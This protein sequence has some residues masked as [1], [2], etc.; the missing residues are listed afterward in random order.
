MVERMLHNLLA[1][2]ARHTPEDATIWVTCRTGAADATIE[3]ADDGPGIAPEDRERVFEPF[4]Q[5]P[6]SRTAPSP[7]TGIGLALVRQFAVLHGGRVAVGARPGGGALFR[8]VLPLAPD[9]QVEVPL[10][11]TA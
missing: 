3:V 4:W 5:G 6:A 10:A 9:D 7:G 1:N 11:P 8:V 2:A